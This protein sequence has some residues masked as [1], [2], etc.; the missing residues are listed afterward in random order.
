MATNVTFNKILESNVP[1]TSTDGNIIFSEQGNMYVYDKNGVK[2]KISDVVFVD[3]LP[4]SPISF[5]IYILRT[6]NYSFNIYDGT[7]WYKL[8]SSNQI[9]IGNSNTD[10]TKLWLDTTD[11]AKPV[12]KWYNSTTSTWININGT[13][14]TS[15]LLDKTTYKG[16]ADGI[17]K[18]ADTLTGMTSTVSQIDNTVNNSISVDNANRSNGKV[19]SYNA[20]TGNPEWASITVTG[21]IGSSQITNVGTHIDIASG[22][23]KTFVHPVSTDENMIINVQ[24]QIEG[25][26]VTNTHIDFSDGSK[27]SFQDSGKM[28]V[29]SNKVQLDIYT[30]LLMHMDDNTFKDECGH[31]INNTGVILDTTNK[32]FGNSSAYFNGSS[33]ITIP[34]STDFNFGSNDFTIDFRIKTNVTNQYATIMSRNNGSFGVGSWQIMLNPTVGNGNIVIYARDYSNTSPLLSVTTKSLI[35]N[36]F[37][38]ITWEKRGSQHTLYIDGVIYSTNTTSF[39]FVSISDPICIG[40][41]MIISGRNYSGN[42]DEL[43]ISNGIA[44]KKEPFIPQIQMYETPYYLSN[45]PTYLKTTG[46]SNYSLTT[47]DTIISLNMPVIIP[48]NTSAKCLFSVDNGSSWLYKDGT[49]IHKYTG[50]LTQSWTSGNTNTELQTYF[51]NLSIAQLKF[52]LTSL[53]LEPLTLDF[54]W[55]LS[56]SDLS[57]TPTIN[58]ITSIYTEAPHTELASF[59]GYSE[60]YV[61]FGVKR[62]N[63]NTLAVKNLT[64]KAR[65]INVNVAIKTS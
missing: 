19:V 57:V 62:V 64:S 15:T 9:V 34:N 63:S 21:I 25:N 41:D 38:N 39:S 30:K 29:D 16:S 24:E 11:S 48:T 45:I 65:K 28:C 1:S 3:T 59:G 56:T 37:Y 4:V 23:E 32:V 12:F 54:I 55:Q 17:V 35:D 2:N 31:T 60:S 10:T 46:Q 14:D 36:K 52:D 8:G 27:Y 51:T 43:L 7:K 6:D 50:D 13:I 49:G 42:I 18:K 26:S 33:Y 53:G 40:K 61:R 44:K 22:E 58:P 20:S 5:K 47:I